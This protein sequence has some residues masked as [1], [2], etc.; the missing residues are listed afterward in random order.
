[1]N[2][3]QLE[4]HHLTTGHVAALLDGRLNRTER[5]M[6]IAHLSL[7]VECRHELAELQRALTASS[8]H[9]RT[10]RRWKV[11]ASAVAAALVFA[12]LPAAMLSARRSPR[13]P[14]AETPATRAAGVSAVDAM[15]SI[16]AIA[17]ADE[18]EIAVRPE[19][20]WRSAGLGATYLVTVQ[21]TSGAAIWS[22]TLTDTTAA[23]PPS[24]PL[25]P[26]HRYFWSVDARLADGGSTGTGM[27]MFTVR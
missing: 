14:T 9:G 21:D 10:R 19:F 25:D 18:A 11:A 8:P 1:M 15:A 12:V 20:R 6:A 4:I 24:I 13:V 26:G 23:S 7:C 2:T 3:P 17:P 22:V 16:N 27:R 5:S